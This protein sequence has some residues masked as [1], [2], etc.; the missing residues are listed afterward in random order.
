M[1]YIFEVENLKCG[2]CINS[3]KSG[4]LSLDGVETVEVELGIGRVKVE[5]KT[6]IENRIKS[7]LSE[8]GYPQKGDNTLSKQ[9]QSYISC[10]SGK[11]FGDKT[12][13]L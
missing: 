7:K 10:V 4:L 9:V 6:N 2:G 8:I 5:S 1:Q 13:K 11:I 3:L 12:N